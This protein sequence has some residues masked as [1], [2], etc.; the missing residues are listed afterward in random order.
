VNTSSRAE[1]D[2]MSGAFVCINLACLDDADPAELAAV[3]V[4]YEDGANDDWESAPV[5]FSHL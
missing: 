4:R 1:F 2:E 5:F 3:Q